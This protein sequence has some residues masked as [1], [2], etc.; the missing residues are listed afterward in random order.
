[1]IYVVEKLLQGHKPKEYWVELL[2]GGNY[3]WPNTNTHT[4]GINQTTAKSFV[5]YFGKLTELTEISYIWL[6]LV[7]DILVDELW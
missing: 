6:S 5:L 1:M 2:Y 4:A 3:L 7:I